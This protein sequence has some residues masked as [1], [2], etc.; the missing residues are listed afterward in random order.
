MVRELGPWISTA[1]R[2][3]VHAM[4]SCL[5]GDGATRCAIFEFGESM[6]WNTF[7]FGE[8]NCF[9]FL[10]FR[11]YYATVPSGTIVGTFTGVEKPVTK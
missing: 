2:Q 3:I 11:V 1:S 7:E 5:G 9:D 10:M 6:L 8:R 4:V